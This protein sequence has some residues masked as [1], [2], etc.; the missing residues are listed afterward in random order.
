[1]EEALGA[2]NVFLD[3]GEEK[4][5]GRPALLGAKEEKEG[6]LEGGVCFKG[7]GVKVEQVGFDSEGVLAEGGAVADVGDTLEGFG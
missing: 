2:G 7:D 5:G 1:M 6:E 3:L 4:V